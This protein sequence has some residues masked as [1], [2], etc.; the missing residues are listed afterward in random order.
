MATG[1]SL[2]A[3]KNNG[4]FSAFLTSP[5]VKRRIGEMMSGDEGTRFVGALVSAVS[6]NPALQRCE[7]ATVLTAALTGHSLKLPFNN[8]L[9]MYYIVPFEDNRNR[10]TVGTF[11]LGLI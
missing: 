10:R 1:N 4:G 9:G 2:Q 6:Q 8:A 3:V 5:A 11:Q 7:P